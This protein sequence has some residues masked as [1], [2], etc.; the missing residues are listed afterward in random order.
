MMPNIG[1]SALAIVAI[2][3]VSFGQSDARMAFSDVMGF[4]EMNDQF[5][6][7]FVDNIIESGVF[8]KSEDKDFTDIVENLMQSIAMFTKLHTE[9]PD[10]KKTLMTAFASELAEL[11][12]AECDDDAMSAVEKTK[13]VTDA[14]RHAYVSLGFRPN[15]T[16]IKEVDFLV[17][18]FLNVAAQDAEM[19]YDFQ[20][21]QRETR[22]EGFVL[23]PGGLPPPQNRYTQYGQET[24]N[25]P[26]VQPPPPPQLTK[27]V[28]AAGMNPAPVK[29]GLAQPPQPAKRVQPVKPVKPTEPKLVQPAKPAQP[30]KPPQPVKPVEPPQPVKPVEPPQPVQPVQPV[31]PAQPVQPVEPPQPVQPVKKP[32]HAPRPPLSPH[33]PHRM[34]VYK[35][36][37]NTYNGQDL[38]EYKPN[39]EYAQRGTTPGIVFGADNRILKIILPEGAEYVH[40]QTVIGQVNELVAVLQEGG[41]K[42]HGSGPD[43]QIQQVMLP[44]LFGIGKGGPKEVTIMGPREQIIRIMRQK[45]SKGITPGIVTSSDK[46]I[47]TI[48]LPKKNPANQYF[49]VKGPDGELV[50]IFLGASGSTPKVIRDNLGRI[51]KVILPEFTEPGTITLQPPN[52]QTIHISPEDIKN[53]FGSDI[54]AH[55][56]QQVLMQRTETG[57]GQQTISIDSDSSDSSAPEPVVPAAKPVEPVPEPVEPAPAPLPVPQPAKPLPTPEPSISESSS[58]S[59]SKETSINII[60]EGGG[61]SP[62]TSSGPSNQIQQIMLDSG[63]GSEPEAGHEQTI[64]IGSKSTSSVPKPVESTPKNKQSISIHGKDTKPSGS[65]PAEPTPIPAPLPVE[66]PVEP[67]P[68]PVEPAPTPS[69]LPVEPTP[70]LEPVKPLPTPEPERSSESSTKQTSIN[71]MQEGGGSSP[72]TS[73]GPS[74]QIQQ[75]MLDSGSGSEPEATHEQTISIGSKSTS[76]VPKPVQSTPKNPKKKQSISIHEKGTKSSGSK[77]VE[78]APIPSPLPAEKPVEPAPKPVEPAPT[79]SPLPAEPSPALEPVTPLPTPEPEPSNESSTKQTSIN[80]MQEGGG[81]SPDTSSGPS[82]QIQQVMLDSGSGSE[83]EATHEQTISI[84]SKSTSSVPKPVQSTPKNPKKKQSIS[85]HEKGTKSSG[86]K[87]VEPAPIPAP[88]PAEKPVEPVPK[89]IEP[90]PTPSPL[91]VEPTPA[92]EPVTPLPTPE[93]EP[94]SESSTKQTSIN[95]MQ[96]GGGSSPDTSSGPSNQIQQVMLD[97]GSGSEPEATHEQTIS[98]GSKTTSSVPQP[99]EST[100]KKKQSIS[101]HEKDTG[102]QPVEPTPIPAPEIPQ[103]LTPVQPET[104]SY[105]TGALGG[106]LIPPVN[107]GSLSP[108]PQP[109]EPSPIPEP[110]PTPV[111]PLIEPV[112]SP[113]DSSSSSEEGSINI[114]QDGGGS[115]RDDSS[116]PTNQIQQIMMSDSE[117]GQ[118]KNQIISI[119]DQTATPT[120]NLIKESPLPEQDITPV[121]EPVP[122]PLPKPHHHH[123]HHHHHHKRHGI[124][125]VQRGGGHKHRNS[126]TQIQQVMLPGDSDSESD[127]D[128]EKPRQQIISLHM[129]KGPQTAPIPDIQQIGP[130]PAP[131]P[132]L[133]PVEPTPAPAPLPVISAPNVEE[134][135]EAPAVE[136]IEPIPTPEPIEPEVPVSTPQPSKESSTKDTS[137]NIMQKGGS[138]SPGPSSAP[139]NQ[140]Q[141]IMLSEDSKPSKEESK[142]E[143]PKEPEQVVKP[144]EPLPELSP[145][146]T[147]KEKKSSKKTSINIMQEGTDDKPGEKAP[148]N[149]IQ[150]VM[151]TEDSKSKP[152]EQ[153]IDISS[154]STPDSPVPESTPVPAPEL[155]PIPTPQPE[156][157]PAPQP[158]PLPAPQPE[159]LPSLQPEPIE[160]EVPVSTPQPSKESSTKDTSINIMQKGGSSSPGPSSAPKNQIQ[161]IMLSEDSKPSKEESKPEKPKEPDQI[162]KPAEPVP[163]LSPEPKKKEKKPSKKTSINIMQKGSDDKPGEKAPKNQIQQ[164][165]QTEDSKSKPSEQKIDISSDSTPDSPVPEPTPVP[166]PELEPLPAPQ[167]EPLPAP[168]PEPLPVP[169]PEPLPAPQPEPLPAPKPLESSPESKKTTEEKSINIVQEGTGSQ[170]GGK[171]P[172]NQIQQIMVSSSSKPSKEVKSKSEQPSEPIPL[173]QPAIPSIAPEPAQ[174]EPIPTPK[175]DEP[176]PKDKTSSKKTSINIMQERT[177][178]K[179]GD[180]AP[181]NQIQQVMISSDSKPAKDAEPTPLPQP[182]APQPVEQVPEPAL[183]TGVKATGLVPPTQEGSAAPPPLRS[184]DRLIAPD[185]ESYTRFR[186]PQRH[187]GYQIEPQMEY[188][189]VQ[190]SPGYENMGYSPYQGLGLSQI[191]NVFNAILRDSKSTI[192]SI[193]RILLKAKGTAPQTIDLR[194]IVNELQSIF[195]DL[196]MDHFYLSRPELFME[197]IMQTLISAFEIIR[198]ADYQCIRNPPALGNTFK[199]IN[200]FNDILF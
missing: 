105:T 135:I 194:V 23:G 13:S 2:C 33:L 85:I 73:S 72:D 7:L 138:S 174:V 70:A 18:V 180:K 127:I 134:P 54:S 61:S 5:A 24:F 79:P 167:P 15:E 121:P 86:S 170:P 75:I 34:T 147:E 154:D 101:I 146:P 145:E 53:L 159:P 46:T 185:E 181:K 43:Y 198:V 12:V 119:D 1:W 190:I 30:V 129:G 20:M 162:V 32:K 38:G 173:P 50:D 189:P 62:G 16:F 17:G 157:L 197:L 60:Q 169:Q 10:Q 65:Q 11:I 4:D 48:I 104:V 192:P 63:S 193:I 51:S 68:K 141:Q 49:Q 69:P 172:K 59:S 166:V 142:P 115:D 171:A 117:P 144:A 112:S 188:L 176:P 165:M 122:E 123:H 78:P 74:N 160:P 102:S 125:I 148:K 81:S 82:N 200:A 139:K 9:P 161:Q 3:I 66:K 92:L 71:I 87:P 25:V 149:Q 40:P 196:Q 39:I 183:T 98:I 116:S 187:M 14:L 6:Q 58:E 83:P 133:A 113:E 191:E 175:L 67:A 168:Q 163:E 111:Q 76:S 35:M 57:P 52:L 178:S 26:Q 152:S 132:S 97:S 19:D 126:R 31:H 199:Y 95:I 124:N 55:Q 56:I 182:A 131:I 128:Y 140:I 103:P 136:P 106:G 99:I 22:R 91:P 108:V 84:G 77:P 155:E 184:G 107:Q 150:Q 179:P 29:T 137:I 37:G 27:G 93:P 89:P 153:K 21:A 158:E 151:Q 36:R 164:V 143:K 100:P 90:A 118:S 28:K 156:P 8:G 114:V 186:Y 64:S 130:T 88:L 177:G 110:I 47:Q 120:N 96:E 195:S 42:K 44:G 41:G 45:R 109:L 80:I 94:S